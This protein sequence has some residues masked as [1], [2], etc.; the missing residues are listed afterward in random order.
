MIGYKSLSLIKCVD[1]S[2]IPQR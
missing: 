2:D 1:L